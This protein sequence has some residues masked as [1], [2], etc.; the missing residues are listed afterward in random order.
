MAQDNYNTG[1]DSSLVVENRSDFSFYGTDIS[2]RHCTSVSKEETQEELYDKYK[3][4]I[5]ARLGGGEDF[6]DI[7]KA[8]PTLEELF[9]D[10]LAYEYYKE[11]VEESKNS[12]TEKDILDA[13]FY[14]QDPGEKFGYDP[15]TNT[16]LFEVK[17]NVKPTSEQI[18]L[19]S[20]DG[21]TSSFYLNDFVGDSGSF[22]MKNG[23]SYNSFK[24]YC[25]SNGLSSEKVSLRHIGIDCAEIPHYEV[26]PMKSTDIVEMTIKEAKQKGAVY[27]KYDYNDKTGTVSNRKDSD[28]VRFFKLNKTDYFE[29]IHDNGIDYLGNTSGIDVVNYQYKVIITQDETQRENLDDAYKAKNELINLLNNSKRVVVKLDANGTKATKTSSKYK[30]YYNH[31]W[32]AHKAIGDMLDLWQSASAVDIPLSSLRH[33]PYGTDGYSRFL[34][35]VYVLINVN[36]KDVWVN[37]NKY[38]LAKTDKTIANPDFTGSPESNAVYSNNSTGF[39]LWSYNRDNLIYLD[40]FNEQTKQSYE[41]RINFHKEIT[42]IDFTAFRNCTMMIGDTL[43]LIPPTSIKNTSTIEYEKESI[44][45]GKGSM[46]KNSSNR[47]QYLEIDLYF[48]DDYGINGIRYDQTLPNGKKM[49][50]YMNGLRS[51]IAQFKVA[52][53]LPIENQYVNDILG[54]EVVSLMNLSI[55]TVEGYPRLLQATL[56]LREFNYRIFMPDLP[57]DS[58]EDISEASK[59]SEMNPIF[60]KCIHWPVF[61]YYYQRLLA[62]GN[63]LAQ[64][65]YNSKEYL[66]TYYSTG[67]AL[68]PINFCQYSDTV[69]FFVPDENW[70]KNAL[71]YKK[72]KEF[73]GQQI[74]PITLSDRAKK[75][76]ESLSKTLEDEKFSLSDGAEKFIIDNAQVYVDPKGE[77][78]FKDIFAFGR[79]KTLLK[80]KTDTKIS[81]VI[82]LKNLLDPFID[83]LTSTGALIFRTVDEKYNVKD[84]D[85]GK[86]NTLTW[87]VNF[88]V[89]TSKLTTEDYVNIKQSIQNILGDSVSVQD[90]FRNNMLSVEINALLDDNKNI[91]RLNLKE[92]KGIL[93]ALKNYKPDSDTAANELN[94]AHLSTYDYNNPAAMQFVPY[95]EHIPATALAYNMT[96]VFTEMSLKIMDGSAPQY[97]G[98]SDMSIELR[99]VT[100]DSTTISM[101]NA[102]PSLAVNISKNYRKI[103]SCWPIRI[104]NSYLQMAGI[105]E[106]IIDNIH[107]DNVEGYPGLYDI[108]LKMTSLDRSIRQREMLKQLDSSQITTTVKNNAM[109]DYFDLEKTLAQ[110]EL[111]PD[112]SLP[113]LKEL[114]QI[115]YCFIK[116]SNTNRIYPDPDFYMVYGFEYTA[117]IIKKNIKEIFLDTLLKSSQDSEVNARSITLSDQDG[118]TFET[119]IEALKGLTTVAMNDQ[120]RWYSQA[121]NDADAIQ[122]GY[123]EATG[124]KDNT[125]FNEKKKEMAVNLE[126][127]TLC[128]IQEGWSI[129]PGWK[130]TMVPDYVNEEVK[131]CKLSNHCTDTVTEQQKNNEYA[132]FLFEKRKRALELIDAMIT[133]P[134]SYN[135]V[136]PVSNEKGSSDKSSVEFSNDYESAIKYMFVDDPNGRELVSLLSPIQH[137]D[138]LLNDNKHTEYMDF[139]NGSHTTKILNKPYFLNYIQVYLQA[140]G[141]TLSGKTFFTNSDKNDYTEYCPNQFYNIGSSNKVV[142]MCQYEKMGSGTTQARDLETALKYGKSFG[143]FNISIETK[144]NILNRVKPTDGLIDY[145]KI[146]QS[147]G[148]DSVYSLYKDYKNG[149]LDPYYNKLSDNDEEL[150]KYKEQIS[151]SP[152]INTVAYLRLV[153]LYLRKQIIEG[154]F[155]S[156]IDIVADDWKETYNLFAVE[157]TNKDFESTAA[158]DPQSSETRKNSLGSISGLLNKLGVF[159]PDDK[160]DS[161]L[162]ELAEALMSNTNGDAQVDTSNKTSVDEVTDQKSFG[163]L[164]ED[165]PKSYSKSFCAR[166]I[167]PFLEAATQSI[168]GPDETVKTCLEDRSYED[169]DILMTALNTSAV[170]SSQPLSKFLTILQHIMCNPKKVDTDGTSLSQKLM[171][172]ILREAFTKLSEDPQAYTLHS[173]YDMLVNDKRGRLLRAFPTYYITF[174]DEGRRI[175]SWK[176][177]DN[178]YNMSAISELTVTKSRKLPADTCSFVMTNLYGSYASEYDTTTRNQ[179]TDVYSLRDVFT[180]IFS[181]ATYVAKEDILARREDNT[182]V[183]VLQPG[184]RLHIRMGYGSNAGDLPIVFNGKI[185]E[186]DVGEYVTVIGQGDGIE[187]VNPLNAL[188]EV[189]AK[190]LIESQ[191]LITWFK[192]LRGSM[193]RG[194]LSPRNLMVQILTAQHG[195]IVKNALKE[196]SNERFYSENPFGIY[197]FGDRHVKDI[198]LEGESVQ[199]LYEV[200]DATLL[201]G[202]NELRPTN[203]SKYSTPTINTNIQDKTAWDILQLCAYS[204]VGYIGAVRDFGFRSTVCLCKPNHYYAYA[205]TKTDGK[206]LEK[207]KPFQQFHYIDS[208]TDIIYNS[209]KATEKNMKTNA[210]G[211]W[212]GTDLLFGSSQKTVGPIYLDMNIYPEYQ[213]SMTVDTTLIASGNGGIDFNPFT[214]FSEEWNMDAEDDKVNKSLAERITTNTLRESVMNMYSGEICIIGNPAIKPHDRISVIDSYED[215]QGQMEVEGVVYSMNTATGF[216]TTIYPDLIVRMNDPY[217][218]PA[219][220][221][222]GNITAAFV[223]TITGRLLV[224]N[225]LSRVDSKI[226][227]A[228]GA[229]LDKLIAMGTPEGEA[230]K[231]FAETTCG[232]FLKIPKVPTISQAFK[233][234]FK[235]MFSSTTVTGLATTMA[236]AA[237]VYVCTRNAKS[238][239]TRWIRN[240]QA[241]DVYP[242]MKNKRPYLAGM[243]GH[244]GSV[245]GYGYSDTDAKDSIQG[246]IAGCVRRIDDFGFGLGKYF[247]NIFVDRSEYNKALQGW[248]NTLPSLDPAGD[249]NTHVEKEQFL[250]NVYDNISTEFRSRNALASM[251]KT[252]P[253][254]RKFDT[255]GGTL[256]TYKQY[257]ISSVPYNEIPGNEKI[258]KLVPIEQDIDVNKALSGSHPILKQFRIIHNEKGVA[259]NIPFE[260]G[261]RTIYTLSDVKTGKYSVVDM[262]LLH[263]DAL[264]IL[265]FILACDVLKGKKIVFASG[266][267]INDSRSWKNTGLAFELQCNDMNALSEAAKLVKEQTFWLI[268]GK[269]AP[270]FDYKINEKSCVITV[271]APKQ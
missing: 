174:I 110:A 59:I 159:N 108:R 100:D 83:S 38:V 224:I 165:I 257:K 196:F 87:T 68:R 158:I 41:D 218:L 229:L 75:F 63:R 97:M 145:Y 19:N 49:T 171:N 86:A 148:H 76:L 233:E 11:L 189:E 216:T 237:T 28:K 160:D 266:A 26:Q 101:I 256:D 52:P 169:L 173:F 168:E 199:N 262:P 113:T 152:A 267:R 127:L 35:E 12:S 211:I 55:N 175:G 205:Y 214:H 67:E 73:Y 238:Y 71:Q 245:V 106:V 242:V 16:F 217:E 37:A 249:F 140:S 79:G 212:E 126:Y 172:K 7:T 247:L 241:L 185:A 184:V 254:L 161:F 61:R 117:K 240:I 42:G 133:V 201:L 137:F 271:Y 72:D 250:Q 223:G 176:L 47:E 98:S 188:G 213:K 23:Q 105:N 14:V 178:F 43:F 153:L 230:V 39:D 2:K 21:D 33:C 124:G 270:I 222:Y 144:N 30:L 45:R 88:A 183:T 235:T 31:W 197:H 5:M 210:V 177:F 150:I 190:S 151:V 3:A 103:L 198:F 123:I 191:S 248:V 219:A 157:M 90:I 147:K 17:G 81:P 34:G 181:P 112:L 57:I 114:S 164:L 182:E 29:I 69:S 187:L 134:I 261:A 170:T 44:L 6:I 36:G 143:M 194:G 180:S 107:I 202:A 239:L 220:N 102:L 24:D 129:R 66:E 58:P 54:I 208:F 155:F 166:M 128:D 163:Q 141:C 234:S 193:A 70:L 269:E 149:F 264:C 99:I 204:G 56:V 46:I 78:S 10:D 259:M 51:L 109:N 252:K 65:D 244:K 82:M 120:A 40:S 268:E 92:P 225:A 80:K 265:K 48:Y 132:I 162:E 25:T 50:Y 104:R 231:K 1:A 146:G 119:E 246:L 192:D 206:L 154:Q 122:H 253:R 138:S 32:F 62:N 258:L 93:N 77:T 84:N 200:S 22:T 142:P 13:V 236:I 136:R 227:R 243:S 221:I 18:A 228:G 130:A 179:Y 207:R 116:Y 215:M 60:A 135:S 118:M 95:L 167:Y 251:L 186:V 74:M 255:A 111:Y 4:M 96:N 64:Y 91:T 15:D 195:G 94:S 139:T 89:D 226:L 209:I 156:E 9:T 125:A 263:E 131:Y 85:K 53:Y 20:I 121:L 8:V 115:G 232:K 27:R 203:E 260:S